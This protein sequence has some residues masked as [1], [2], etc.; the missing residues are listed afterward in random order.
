PTISVPDRIPATRATSNW[1]GA[2]IHNAAGAKYYRASGEFVV[3]NIESHGW[4][5]AVVEEEAMSWVGLDGCGQSSTDLM[6]AGVDQYVWNSNTAHPPNYAPVAVAY[7][8]WAAWIGTPSPYRLIPST[9]YPVYLGDYTTVTVW[10]GDSQGVTNLAGG[11]GGFLWF[12]IYDDQ[13]DFEYRQCI[14]P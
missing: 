3:P 13:Q 4:E 9:S 5:Q 14:G 12:D 10:Q 11:S 1:S 2:D 8:A 7:N 6:Q